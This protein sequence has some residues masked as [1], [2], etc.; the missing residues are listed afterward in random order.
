MVSGF[1]TSS[2]ILTSCH[3]ASF[4][5]KSAVPCSQTDVPCRS[6]S[7][8]QTSAKRR[9]E[10]TAPGLEGGGGVKTFDR[11]RYELSAFA[12]GDPF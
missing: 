9:L 3:T 7:T 5:F 10:V 12:L 8:N 2:A 6:R 1:E 11:H 4:Q